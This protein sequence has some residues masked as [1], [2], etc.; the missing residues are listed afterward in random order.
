MKTP[1]EILPGPSTS[2]APT[3]QRT[4]APPFQTVEQAALET[5][6]A[7]AD[8]VLL[9]TGA[10]GLPARVLDTRVTNAG[11]LPNGPFQLTGPTMPYDA[12]TGD[13]IHRF[14]QMWQQSDCSLANATPHNPSGCLND[15][16][17]FVA[18]TFSTADN[19]VGSSMAFFNVND[20]DAPYFTM[21]ADTYSMRQHAPVGARRHRR[22]PLAARLRRRGRVDRRRRQPGDAAR[23]RDLQPEPAGGQ[24]QSLHPRRQLQQLLGRGGTGRER[25]GGLPRSAPPAAGPQLRRRR[26]STTFRRRIARTSTRS[27]R[28]TAAQRAPSRR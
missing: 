21:L 6:I 20:G 10:T 11:N 27:F 2:G 3:A 19:G 8:L 14:Y 13:T 17:P 1:Y 28:S 12:Y 24:Q 9:T 26:S 16:Y 7:P 18:M 25:R 15:L 4:T 22:Q 5:D 23:E